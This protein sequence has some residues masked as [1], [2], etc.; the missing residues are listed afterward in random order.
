MSNKKGF[1]GAEGRGPQKTGEECKNGGMKQEY[2]LTIL[3]VTTVW[4]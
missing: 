3:N 1:R 2:I 4:P